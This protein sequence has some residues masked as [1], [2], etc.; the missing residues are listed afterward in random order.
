M[1]N[2]FIKENHLVDVVFILKSK[3]LKDRI[4]LF[5][6]KNIKFDNIIISDKNRSIFSG[7][8]KIVK[9]NF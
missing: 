2:N 5:W 3:S 7:Y 8:F 6:I 4:N 9:I 1:N